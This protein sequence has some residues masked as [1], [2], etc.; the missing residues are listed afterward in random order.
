M[1]GSTIGKQLDVIPNNQLY[2]DNAS[3]I[4]EKTYTSSRTCSSPGHRRQ[5]TCTSIPPL[6]P[7]APIKSTYRIAH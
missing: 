2:L 1:N 7:A 3:H 6:T 4:T 5:Y